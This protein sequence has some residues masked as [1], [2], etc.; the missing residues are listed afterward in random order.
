[1]IEANELKLARML[2]G[3]CGQDI[4]LLTQGGK[5]KGITLYI[6]AVALLKEELRAKQQAAPPTLA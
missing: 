6:Q 4:A 1:M 3:R 2:I 5:Q